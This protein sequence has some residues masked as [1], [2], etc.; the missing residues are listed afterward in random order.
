L[1]SPKR[2]SLTEKQYRTQKKKKK[3]QSFKGEEETKA[4]EERV[5][6]LLFRD[7]K[8]NGLI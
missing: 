7:R 2:E 6:R 3:T 1:L 5:S 8:R 4:R